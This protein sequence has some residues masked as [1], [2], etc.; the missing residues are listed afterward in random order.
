MLA[1]TGRLAFDWGNKAPSGLEPS[2]LLVRVLDLVGTV[3]F[4]HRQRRNVRYR[5]YALQSGIALPANN[6]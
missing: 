4:T 3:V 2:V 5:Q 6:V 1:A